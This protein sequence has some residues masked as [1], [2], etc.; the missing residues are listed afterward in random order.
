M[1]K[2]SADHVPCWGLPTLY[3]SVARCEKPFMEQ[4]FT[5]RGR[6]LTPAALG[7]QQSRCP[8]SVPTQLPHILPMTA[9]G[10]S[11]SREMKPLLVPES[12][13]S[14]N[15]PSLVF[16]GR[17][18]TLGTISSGAKSMYRNYR[19]RGR[20]GDDRVRDWVRLLLR[21]SKKSRLTFPCSAG[22]CHKRDRDMK[23]VWLPTPQE[24][25]A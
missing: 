14:P 10:N 6:L 8:F 24:L 1:F 7:P 2:S 19:V 17:Q 5:Y 9:L 15:F 23:Q 4:D 22:K 20:G 3:F 12:H 11:S 21:L 13:H 16:M 18:G 25:G